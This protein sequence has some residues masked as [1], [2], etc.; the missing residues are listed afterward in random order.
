MGNV[1]ARRRSVTVAV[2]AGLVLQLLGVAGF[3]AEPAGAGVLQLADLSLALDAPASVVE[4]ESIPVEVTVADAGP[5]DVTGA[6]V[7][8][9]VPD[10]VGVVAD[11]ASTC[12]LGSPGT[13][14][15]DLGAIEQGSERSHTLELTGA[16]VGTL[17]L[18]GSVTAL[19]YDDPSRVDGNPAGNDLASVRVEVVATPSH[20]TVDLQELDGLDPVAA[21]DPLGYSI[22]VRQE[23]GSTA[24]APVVTFVADPTTPIVAADVVAGDPYF[25]DPR[26]EA[27]SPCT[28]DELGATATCALP[29]VAPG[30]AAHVLVAVAAPALGSVTAGAS[31]DDA[32]TSAT[33]DAA[34]DEA[35]TV[36]AP[37]T[38][39]GLQVV[40]GTYRA[41]LPYG[42]DVYVSNQG[43][44]AA[45][46]TTLV[47]TFPPGELVA[48]SAFDDRGD[49]LDCDLAADTSTVT[50][51]YP[52]MRPLRSAY[53]TLQFG[54]ATLEALPYRFEVSA[55]D[56]PPE[57]APNDDVVEGELGLEAAEADLALL[58]TEPPGGAYDV[59]DEIQVRYRVVDQGPSPATGVAVD[60]AMPTGWAVAGASAG[61]EPI[62][63]AITCDD[64]TCPLPDLA[65][66]SSTD[67]LVR[68]VAGTGSGPVEAVV[69]AATVDPDPSDDR[70]AFDAHPVAPQADLTASVYLPPRQRVDVPM[71]GGRA[72]AFNHGPRMALVSLSVTL[73]ASAS[74]LEAVPDAPTTDC[75]TSGSTVTCSGVVAPG[76]TLG[77]TFTAVPHTLG[78]LTVTSHVDADLEDPV[79]GNDEASTTTQVVPNE[80]ELRLL[81]DTSEDGFPDEQ[82]IRV[83]VENAGPWRADDVVLTVPLPDD[84]DLVSS[85]L[86]CT[87]AGAPG[88]RS[89]LCP[90]GDL[91]PSTATAALVGTFTVGLRGV[92]TRTLT[93]TLRSSTP[94]VGT[95]DDTATLAL[96]HGEY[97]GEG[98]D[99]AT[100]PRNDDRSSDRVHLPFTLDF[101]GRSYDSLF[102]NNNGNVSF[103]APLA[104]YTPFGL[105]GTNL[106]II[107]PWFADV[108]TRTADG[109]T[110]SY[111]L[112]TVD[113][114]RAFCVD[115]TEVGYY[116]QRTDR[117]N[118]F[119][120][121]LVDRGDGDFDIRFDYDHLRWDIGEASGGVAAAAGFSNG[122]GLE[123]E[124]FELDGSRTAG[125]LLDSNPTTGLI[126]RTQGAD[127]V[128]GRFVFPVR[129]GRPNTDVTPPTVTGATADPPANA[130]GW[131]RGDADGEVLVAFT[132]TDD[133]GA[134]VTC[135][136]VTYSGPDSADATVT[137][138]CTDAAGNVSAPFAFPLPYDRT[139]PAADCP[140]APA[141]GGAWRPDDVVVP[142]TVTDATSGVA[143][144]T[145]AS[146]ATDVAAGTASATAST[147]TTAV[148]DVAGNAVAVGPFGPYA[149]DR[150]DPTVVVTAPLDGATYRFGSVPGADTNCDDVGSGLV[151]CEPTAPIDTSVGTHT[152]TFVATDGVGR[153][154]TASTTYRVI[155][156]V[157][158]GPDAAGT[159]GDP[160]ALAGDAGG[161]TAVTWTYRAGP[162]VDPGTT[163]AFDDVEAPATTFRCNDDGTFVVV[164][165]SAD[166][167]AD[168]SATVTLGNAAPTVTVPAPP[169][170]TG[171][172]TIAA[173]VADAGANDPL[174][175][176]IDWGDG[177]S[178][179]VTANG[180]T[181]A[182]DHTYADDADTAI[183]VRVADDDG[184][185][186]SA[187]R[188]VR[189]DRSA[190]SITIATP[191]DGSTFAPGATVLA[192]YACA[193]AVAGVASCAG[194]VADGAPIDTTAGHHTFT[195][196][197]TDS[198]GNTGQRTVAYDVA[199]PAFGD[200]RVD[201]TAIGG[202]VANVDACATVT[203]GDGSV[204][205]ACDLVNRRRDGVITFLA[206]PAG[207]VQL[208]V[209]PVASQSANYLVVAPASVT[210][211]AG[212]TTAVP[213]T[214][215]RLAAVNLSI[216][217]LFRNAATPGCVVFTAAFEGIAPVTRCV[218]NSTVL[219]LPVGDWTATE[220]T[221]FGYDARPAQTF[222][223]AVSP[224]PTIRFEHRPLAL[225][226]VR[227]AAVGP[228]Q[229]GVG[230]ASF[231]P[232]CA[233]VAA[234]DG[235]GSRSACAATASTRFAEIAVPAGTLSVSFGA[236]S[237]WVTPPPAAVAAV[238]GATSTV[239]ATYRAPAAVQVALVDADTG[240]PIGLGGTTCPAVSLRFTAAFPITAPPAPACATRDTFSVSLPSGPWNLQ[241]QGAPAGYVPLAAPVAWDGLAPS[242]TIPLRSTAVRVRFDL[243]GAA[244][245]VH[246]DCATIRRGADI[247]ASACA[248][249]SSTV[250]L[251]TVTG[252]APGD[253]TARFPVRQANR[254]AAGSGTSST[255]TLQTPAD[256]PFTVGSDGA[257]VV[258]TYRALNRVRLQERDADTG[259]VLANAPA[260]TPCWTLTP[261]FAGPATASVCGLSGRN[262]FGTTTLPAGDW[263]VTLSTPAPGRVA[264]GAGLWNGADNAL[265]RT[266]D[267]PGGLRIRWT[268]PAGA[269]FAPHVC[270]TVRREGEPVAHPCPGTAGA[271]AS[272]ADLPGLAAGTYVVTFDASNDSGTVGSSTQ[273]VTPPPVTVTVGTGSAYALGTYR[274][275]ATLTLR[276]VDAD[277]GTSLRSATQPC[278][279]LVPQFEGPAT[280][281]VCGT[282]TVPPGG[283]SG[284]GPGTVLTIELPGGGPWTVRQVSTIPGYAVDPVALTWAGVNQTLTFRDLPVV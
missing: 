183:V 102:V 179:D 139:A 157:D 144:P 161:A 165:T 68:F 266:T 178:A 203:L 272:V 217:D 19:G 177:Q 122:S 36:V 175:C 218:P 134:A 43:P 91:P 211:A 209:T 46:P 262:D 260:G 212:S 76:G 114:Q 135:S 80:A 257:L 269:T 99:A 77:L 18:D 158:A 154:A 125:A 141:P 128:L 98:C 190:P 173:T 236:T 64:G 167:A 25:A 169:L 261:L 100:L 208:R 159:E 243:V 41:G 258:G 52:R 117:T 124:S 174:T 198:L 270:A 155:A 104:T 248:V 133:S 192:D 151:S 53:L 16:P 112:T 5:A 65:A 242:V 93:G 180:G 245:F 160:V 50:C 105:A 274:R 150:A 189:V 2:V 97:A 81:L 34:D 226:R 30:E 142:C 232:P 172:V 20:L 119:H 235:S 90:L 89:I 187:T 201:L 138:T 199:T 197:A 152:A 6:R 214:F 264:A 228:P 27:L 202:T 143:G 188:P 225:L 171:A 44:S 51:T 120:L 205:T 39:L 69:R 168:D 170:G 9:A 57:T 67:L 247:V 280:R 249:P 110:V 83:I 195:V 54:E 131:Y 96:A 164:L 162:G 220:T 87:V 231:R 229:T 17:T 145:A 153:T 233:Q 70:A 149:I 56:S 221:P 103:D 136:T 79:P 73:D 29:D 111:G 75:D 132:G 11:E 273:L 45:G 106:P 230:E 204:R 181:C 55:A 109:G 32:A 24:V 277:R 207:A 186:S 216:V 196:V 240:A 72:F 166:G 237:G 146:V 82:T 48:A 223:L 101:Y 8:L 193:D 38:D 244:S 256:V 78:P 130:A 15:C 148:L 66:G 28:V 60:L 12:A 95:A 200:L 238:A 47:G 259:V 163:C 147:G 241:L 71:E 271:T 40:P 182:A 121:L 62:P 282:G 268:A 33:P 42:F 115:W 283:T 252:L 49:P 137:G 263:R 108:D 255:V 21:G 239:D 10:G 14:S 22:V 279:E 276:A 140:S 37:G 222:T 129:N 86:G 23:G 213:V 58:L 267:R 26:P 107:A 185:S 250:P 234:L 84:V 61:P 156:A 116:S 113:G 85:G 251:A 35:T 92:G 191:A 265:V 3:A 254:T 1:G 59:G 224:V 278:F 88:S 63:V 284:T 4:G 281:T 227:F 184:A 118:S 13:I 253:Y 246:N 219:R 215:R 31:V 206:L 176:H 275:L 7:Q 126:H 94:L 194:P 74:D 123:G 210:V 127:R